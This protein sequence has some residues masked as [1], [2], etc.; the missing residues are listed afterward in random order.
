M[1]AP[2]VRSPHDVALETLAEPTVGE[3][4]VLVSPLLAGVCGTDLELID[5]SIAPAYVRC[6]LVHGHEWVGQILDDLPGVASRAERVIVEGIVPCGDCS[7]CQIGATSL[8]TTHNE[9]GFTRPGAGALRSDVTDDE[10]RGK[11]VFALT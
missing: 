3:D 2:V 10:P 1:R 4:E 11:V 8:C 7:E 9:I 6:P 5:G